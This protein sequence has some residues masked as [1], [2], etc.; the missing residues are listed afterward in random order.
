MEMSFTPHQPM[1]DIAHGD[2]RL[3]GQMLGHGNSFHEAL[4]EQLLC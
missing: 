3:L 2:L 1:L 4:N